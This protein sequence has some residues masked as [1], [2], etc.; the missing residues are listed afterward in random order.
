MVKMSVGEVALTWTQWLMGSTAR[1]APSRLEVGSTNEES[2]VPSTVE[3]TK[4]VNGVGLRR[5]MS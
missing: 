1:E 5:A 2:M 3:R 4:S